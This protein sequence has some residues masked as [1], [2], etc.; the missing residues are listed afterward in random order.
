M[1]RNGEVWTPVLERQKGFISKETWVD[2]N[3]PDRVT[4]VIRWASLDHWRAFPPELG[5]Q[6]DVQMGDL[7]SP[8][9]CEAYEAY[10][11]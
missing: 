1:V 5:K 3:D 9:I 7:L 4:L 10:E 2:L 11:A 6:L 8:L